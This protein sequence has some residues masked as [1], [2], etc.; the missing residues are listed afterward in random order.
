MSERGRGRGGGGARGR[1]RGRGGARNYSKSQPRDVTGVNKLKSIMRQTKRLL[2]KVRPGHSYRR[3]LLHQVRVSRQND[4]S[5]PLNG[6]LKN[7]HSPTRSAHWRHDTIKS[8]SLVCMPH[9]T[10]ARTSETGPPYQAVAA[11][12]RC[13]RKY[14]VV[15]CRVVRIARVFKLCVGTSAILAYNRTSLPTSAMWPCL[16]IAARRSLLRLVRM[17]LIG[18][19]SRLLNSC[20]MSAN[21]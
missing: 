7:V 13:I 15:A 2:S 20:I 5:L 21:P 11:F 10:N 9:E 4:D 18:R 8:S 17:H 12:D 19:R 14:K 16:A 6:S 1:G 3:T